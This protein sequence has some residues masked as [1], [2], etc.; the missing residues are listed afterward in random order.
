MSAGIS[1][2]SESAHKDMIA[3]YL[4]YV[5]QALYFGTCQS[6]RLGVRMGQVCTNTSQMVLRSLCS[7]DLFGRIG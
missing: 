3:R 5:G 2:L 4:G 7:V 6:T 1:L